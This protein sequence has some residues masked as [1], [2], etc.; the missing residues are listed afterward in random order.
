MYELKGIYA[1]EEAASMIFLKNEV[2]RL[3]IH[4]HLYTCINQ[5]PFLEYL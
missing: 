2:M 3:S 1:D 4:V 5:Y